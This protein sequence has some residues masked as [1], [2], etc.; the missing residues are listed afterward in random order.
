[1]HFALMAQV[2]R[3]RRSVHRGLV[4]VARWRGWRFLKEKAVTVTIANTATAM[5]A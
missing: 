2:A 3:L 5:R 4:Q 1:M